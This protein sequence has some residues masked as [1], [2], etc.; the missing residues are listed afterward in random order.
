MLSQKLCNSRKFSSLSR[1][2]LDI[3]TARRTIKVSP[4]IHFRIE[5][6][7]SQGNRHR[8]L[9]SGLFY[10]PLFAVPAVVPDSVEFRGAV[11][12]IDEC[13]SPVCLGALFLPHSL[14]LPAVSVARRP[15]LRSNRHASLQGR[16]PA[17]V[18]NL[19]AVRRCGTGFWNESARGGPRRAQR[20]P[21]H[22]AE[23]CLRHDPGNAAGPL[24]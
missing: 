19:A 4:P 16:I 12:L 13:K 20:L 1:F 3:S 7:R 10:C 15:H 22:S 2:A 24:A 9:A 11:F 8:S 17:T 14:G 6:A 18:Q 23:Y 5:W 21:L